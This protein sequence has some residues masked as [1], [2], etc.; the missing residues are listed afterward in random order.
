MTTVRGGRPSWRTPSEAAGD[1]QPGWFV[2][3]T[4]LG[5]LVI[6]LVVGLTIAAHGAQ[7]AFGWWGGGGQIRW[8]ATMLRMGYRPVE[9]WAA[10]WTAAEL[11]GGLMLAFGLMTAV[12]G[13]AVLAQSIVMIGRIHL[14]KGFWNGN[15]GFE[16]PLLIAGIAFAAIIAGPGLLSI[17]AALR[18]EASPIVKV[19]CL[20]GGLLGGLA[21]SAV[22]DAM[23]RDAR[24]S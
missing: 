19:G 13:A 7:K 4:D 21:A 5:L 1:R 14:N 16:Y 10:V 11:V 23:S 3:L 15:G 12:G 9:L 22:P 18:I 8:R 6:R 20:V 24:Q 2:D 17:D